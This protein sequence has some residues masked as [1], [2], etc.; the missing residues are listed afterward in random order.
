MDFLFIV[1][2][3][4][5]AVAGLAAAL[6]LVSFFLTQKEEAAHPPTGAFL[7]LGSRRWHFLS[8][9]EE[10]AETTYVLLH[11]ASSSARDIFHALG[12][13]LTEQGRVIAPDRPGAGHS[14]RAK[15]DNT[16]QA[17]AHAIWQL[18]D[19]LQVENPILIG[20]SWGGAL[21]AAMALERPK[22]IKKLVLVAPVLRQWPGKV[23]WAYRVGNHPFFGSLLCWLLVPLA[24][25]LKLKA[26][27]QNVFAP[28]PVPESYFSKAAPIKT[29]KPSRFLANSQDMANLQKSVGAMMPLYHTLLMPIVVFG[30]QEDGVLNTLFHVEALTA[31]GLKPHVADLPQ[32]GHM[33]HYGGKAELLEL[34]KG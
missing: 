6:F 11:G 7:E 26:A 32:E 13:E 2:M 15:G 29:L 24:G 21:A 19:A 1:V 14:T 23:D 4:L 20:H 5:S 10:T 30:G 9:G 8:G 34:I 18:L 16:P 28:A 17:Q 3:I 27:T 31:Q 22:S 33:P 25:R 12:A